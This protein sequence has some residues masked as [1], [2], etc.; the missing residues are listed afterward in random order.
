MRMG[1]AALLA[2]AVA[3]WGSTGC[4]RVGKRLTALGDL[5]KSADFV[6]QRIKGR[7]WPL[8]KALCESGHPLFREAAAHM[9]KW[10]EENFWQ[11]LAPQLPLEKEDRARTADFLLALMRCEG[12]EN[13]EREQTLWEKDLMARREYLE[14]GE[15]PK[16]RM[17][18][19]VYALGGLALA[20][21]LM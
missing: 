15:L 7:N 4:R 21:A 16:A 11:Q 19:K 14:K 17:L 8:P 2:V 1:A 6:L 9:D 12:E 3:A 10:E 18:K 20:I 13:L 5:A